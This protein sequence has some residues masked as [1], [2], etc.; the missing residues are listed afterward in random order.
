MQETNA[1]SGLGFKIDWVLMK[2]N[3]YLTFKSIKTGQS[4]GFEKKGNMRYN[5][6]HFTLYTHTVDLE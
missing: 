4:G 2:L 3:G 6:G 1:S 5:F